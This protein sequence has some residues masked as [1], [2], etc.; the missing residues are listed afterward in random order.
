MQQIKNQATCFVGTKIMAKIIISV[1]HSYPIEN[2]IQNLNIE[3]AE[4]ILGSGYPYGFDIMNTTDRTYINAADRSTRYDGGGIG[5]I[6]SHDNN[7]NARTSS[8]SIYIY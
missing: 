5:S 6:N 3:Q 2:F 1:L 4:T 7:I 8:R